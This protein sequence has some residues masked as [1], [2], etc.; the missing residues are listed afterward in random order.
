VGARVVVVVLAVVVAA[1]GLGGCGGDGG[2]SSASTTTTPSTKAK[3]ALPVVTYV[4]AGGRTAPADRE[5]LEVAADATFTMQRSVRSP[6]VG[7]FAG[8]LTSQEARL[9]DVAAR[10]A[11]AAGPLTGTRVPDAA[12]ETATVDG[13]TATFGGGT[14]SG[15]WGPLAEQLRRLLDDLVRA[16]EAAVALE[17]APDGTKATLKRL[18]Q[19]PLTVD[20]GKLSVSATL[21]GADGNAMGTWKSPP[22]PAARPEQTDAGWTS[23]LPF[24]HGLEMGAGRKLQ[25][26]ATFVV[27]GG[28][29]LATTSVG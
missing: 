2:G 22:A 18:G 25:V 17:V 3:S 5:R 9:L 1:V 26:A 11:A 21:F 15:P 27:D 20:L 16:P 19:G 10:A 13:V 12:G 8:R 6:S 4:R 14:P 28:P 24:G 23:A 29:V 7:R